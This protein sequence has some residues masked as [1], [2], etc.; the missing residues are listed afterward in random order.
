MLC[1]KVF[2]VVVSSVV[3]VSRS[4]VV[5]A[6]PV[7]LRNRFALVHFP[8]SFSPRPIVFAVQINVLI[9]LTHFGVVQ[10][11]SEVGTMPE[12]LVSRGRVRSSLR[13]TVLSWG[14]GTRSAQLF[15][16]SHHY[17]IYSIVTS[18]VYVHFAVVSRNSDSN[19]SIVLFVNLGSVVSLTRVEGIIKASL[20]IHVFN[21][22]SV[23]SCEHTRILLR[24][25]HL[26]LLSNIHGLM[27]NKV[28]SYSSAHFSNCLVHRL[29]CI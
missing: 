25:N 19:R 12:S 4:V 29:D 9:L 18:G 16:R 24:R 10:R 23:D 13:G 26:E 8:F 3:L 21:W 17:F 6:A 27:I 15:S 2:C 28:V 7:V 14:S 1:S 20:V 22:P 11:P 5:V